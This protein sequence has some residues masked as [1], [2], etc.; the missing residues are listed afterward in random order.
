MKY[1]L[2]ATNDAAKERVV[3]TNTKFGKWFQ[4]GIP[5][6]EIENDVLVFETEAYAKFAANK[7]SCHD[8]NLSNCGNPWYTFTVCEDR[9]NE[10]DALA[11]NPPLG[12][13]PKW[14]WQE[15][16]REQRIDDILAAMQRYKTAGVKIPTEWLTELKEI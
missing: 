10:V 14:S 6:C 9:R 11:T 15:R 12:L 3:A 1:I 7:L 4:T 16:I 8:N 13:E 2:C 5:G